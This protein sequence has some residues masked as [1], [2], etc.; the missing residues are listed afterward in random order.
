MGKFILA[1]KNNM[2]QVFLE[3]GK[4][5]PV[6]ALT[7]LPS[8]VS[9]VKSEEK[10]GYAA[11]QVA[12]GKIKREF[13]TGGD[14]Q[15]GSEL[16]IE[17]VPGEII[18]IRGTSKGKGHTGPVKRHGFHGAPASH[19]H[20]HPRAVGSIGQ[21]F[22]QHVRPGKRMAGHMGASGATV[23]NSM[24]IGIDLERNLIFVKGGV[25]GAP[26]SIVKI[27]ATGAKKDLP[28]VVEYK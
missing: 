6:T 4:V 1:K 25:P 13:R 3:D 12:A 21:R 10:D 15:V 27:V 23:K 19:G 20:D 26:N 28:K 9:A 7:V 5:M 16:K 2:T 22:P 17:L 18:N 24:V 8:Q 14:F 11:V